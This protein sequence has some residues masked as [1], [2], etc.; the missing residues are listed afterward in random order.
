LCC[1][2]DVEV[3]EASQSDMC[4]LQ[5]PSAT[6][7]P[8]DFNS[9]QFWRIQPDVVD[10][11]SV[12]NACGDSIASLVIS[13]SKHNSSALHAVG[14]SAHEQWQS[15]RLP[16]SNHIVKESTYFSFILSFSVG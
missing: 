13:P 2:C 12:I 15:R 3:S 9:F 16:D 7:S 1:R 10:D 6:E 5:Q 11:M 8:D 4:Q 14:D